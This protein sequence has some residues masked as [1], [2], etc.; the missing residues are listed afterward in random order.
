M[1]YL[2]TFRTWTFMIVL[3]L[4]GNTLL[5]AQEAQWVSPSRGVIATG[6]PTQVFDSVF[7]FIRQEYVLQSNTGD[8]YVGEEGDF[9]GK[10]WGIGIKDHHGLIWTA[11][12]VLN[13]WMTD[14]SMSVGKDT[15]TPVRSK[16]TYRHFEEDT[17]HDLPLIVDTASYAGYYFDQSL[18]KGV[19][20][21]SG[22]RSARGVLVMAHSLRRELN[23]DAE[24]HVTVYHLEPGWEAEGK[25]TQI[26][27]E[28][29]LGR[30]VG[31]GYFK[32]D[33]QTG[34]L[35]YT[36]TAICYQHGEQWFLESLP[37]VDQK[38]L[39]AGTRK[40]ER[41]KKEK[42]RNNRGILQQQP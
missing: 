31:G 13:P 18:Q 6:I 12:S 22:E 26:T 2:S 5:W 19:P 29:S 24:L 40:A 1:R 28:A 36:L 7:Y 42:I 10:M 41:E 8:E 38:K 9:F 32:E 27:F 37:A 35:T 39:T 14:S 20:S 33:I 25:P 23:D 34:Q 11:K 30:P 3:H 16:G 4:T 15:L 17:F 21:Q